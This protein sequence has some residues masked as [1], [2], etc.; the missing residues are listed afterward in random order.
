MRTALLLLPLCA[1][2]AYLI[3]LDLPGVL[4]SG[5][6]NFAPPLVGFIHRFSQAVGE[7]QTQ[8]WNHL[9]RVSLLTLVALTVQVASLVWWRRSRDPWWRIGIVYACLLLVLGPAVWE[10]HPGAVTRVV[11]PMTFAFN[12][13]LPRSRWFWPLWLLGN[14]SLVDAVDIVGY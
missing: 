13:L 12:V 14:A 1:W 7:L 8:G 11:L 6:Q 2:I 9:T 10:G 4:S 3:F 5:T